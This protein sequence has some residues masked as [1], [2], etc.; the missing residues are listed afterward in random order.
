MVVFCV[1]SPCIYV[2]PIS[3]WVGS[4]GFLFVGRGVASCAF[5]KVLPY[6]FW[7]GGR[8]RD[9]WHSVVPFVG[10]TETDQTERT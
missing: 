9:F 2:G 7:F 1:P 3:F 6:L 10:H 4:D 5:K 8:A